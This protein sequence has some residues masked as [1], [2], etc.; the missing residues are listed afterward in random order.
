MEAICT[1]FIRDWEL[2]NLELSLSLAFAFLCFIVLYFLT[3]PPPRPLPPPPVFP[4]VCGFQA[5]PEPFGVPQFPAWREIDQWAL[6]LNSQEKDP[7]RYSLG[8]RG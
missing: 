3:I 8:S 6:I 4:V 5:A 2:E 1:D 7:G